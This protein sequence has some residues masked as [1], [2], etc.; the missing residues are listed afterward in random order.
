MYLQKVISRKT[1]FLKLVFCWSLEGSIS[2]KAGSG[3]ISQ[4]HESAD[5]YPHQYV[6]RLQIE[7]PGY[8]TQRTLAQDFRRIFSASSGW[9]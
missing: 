1:F 8:Q 6:M 2:K 9:I 3:S 5:P 7:V 4:R